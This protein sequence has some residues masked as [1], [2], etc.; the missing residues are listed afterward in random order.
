MYFFQQYSQYSDKFFS[1]AGNDE[2]IQ[3]RVGD[4]IFIMTHIVQINDISV[5]QGA[6]LILIA[7]PCVIEDFETSLSIASHL[8]KITERYNIPFIFKASYDKANRTS[9]RSFRGP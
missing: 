4:V 6:P 8:K 2:Y 7:G 5:G 9:L 1:A 3:I